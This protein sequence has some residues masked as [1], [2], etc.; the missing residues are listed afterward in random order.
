MKLGL[1]WHSGKHSSINIIQLFLINFTWKTQC[2]RESVPCMANNVNN[3]I[4]KAFWFY[5]FH[6]SRFK[7]AICTYML[8]FNN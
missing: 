5:C 4:D 8:K 6:V 7:I 1:G 3:K 2:N